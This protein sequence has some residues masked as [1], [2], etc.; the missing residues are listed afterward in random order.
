MK[1]LTLESDPLL[2][3][4]GDDLAVVRVVALDEFGNKPGAVEFERDEVFGAGNLDFA[5]LTEQALQFRNGLGRQDKIALVALWKF[6]IAVEQR[7]AAAIGRNEHEFVILQ[8]K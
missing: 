7:Q 4:A 6:Q 3:F 2:G 1:R 5:V 8:R